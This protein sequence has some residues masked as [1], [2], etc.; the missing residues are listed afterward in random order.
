MSIKEFLETIKIDGE[1]TIYC[2]HKI[3]GFK[4]RN[5]ETGDYEIDFEHEYDSKKVIQI[6]VLYSGAINIYIV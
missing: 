1:Y 4:Y 5:N 3:V 6:E 2:E